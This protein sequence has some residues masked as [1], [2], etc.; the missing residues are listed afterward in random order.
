MGKK[1]KKPDLEMEYQYMQALRG[2]EVP[3]LTLD[4]G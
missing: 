3:L 4:A 1:R 2:K